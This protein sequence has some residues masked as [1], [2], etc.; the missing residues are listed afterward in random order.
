MGTD[1]LGESESR[2]SLRLRAALHSVSIQ[3]L[4]EDGEQNGVTLRRVSGCM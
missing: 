2:V 3:S 4:R 1:G